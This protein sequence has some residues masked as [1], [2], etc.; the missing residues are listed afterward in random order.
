MA[1]S[2][3]HTI[4]VAAGAVLAWLAIFLIAFQVAYSLDLYWLLARDFEALVI[5]MAGLG[6]TLL[7]IFWRSSASHQDK[8][9]IGIASLGAFFGLTFIGGLSVACA[10]GNCL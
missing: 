9:M 5:A 4:L 6:I 8:V 10:N 2:T 3:K 1:L 7:A